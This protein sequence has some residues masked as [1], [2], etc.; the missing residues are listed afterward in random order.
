MART[1]SNTPEPR[2]VKKAKFAENAKG[3]KPASYLTVSNIYT[4]EKGFR[5]AYDVNGEEAEIEVPLEGTD[6]VTVDVDEAN[7]MINVHLDAATRM[8]IGKALVLPAEAPANVA[9]VGVGTNN[10]QTM[11]SVGEGLAVEGSTLKASGGGGGTKLY[12]H[13]I[14]VSLTNTFSAYTD[15]QIS[16][17]FM[18]LSPVSTA[19]ST[20]T[21]ALLEVRRLY[22][23]RDGNDSDC[24]CPGSFYYGQTT[25]TTAQDVKSFLNGL[26][27][28]EGGTTGY[29]YGVVHPTS[30]MP[31]SVQFNVS[32][33]RYYRDTVVE[34]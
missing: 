30:K 3:G 34:L 26:V 12:S 20:L 10:A 17:S 2:Y 27:V 33:A 22:G 15:G 1:F 18:I 23:G 5:V 14:H 7:L 28:N 16:L 13:V 32:S 21:D 8:K 25:E 4:V 29:I 24:P 11:L 9:L 19:F 31:Q 6:D